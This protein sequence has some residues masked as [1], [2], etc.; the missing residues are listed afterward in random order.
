LDKLRFE[1]FQTQNYG[2]LLHFWGVVGQ[3]DFFISQTS[4]S[5]LENCQKNNRFNYYE[6]AA[7]R[8]L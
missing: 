6:G 8:M 7:N 2:I 1:D 3:S 4:V 5:S